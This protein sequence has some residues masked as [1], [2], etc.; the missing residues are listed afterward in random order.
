MQLSRPPCAALRTH[1][2]RIWASDGAGP[3]A[4][5]ARELVVPTGSVHLVF[6]LADA[7]LRVLAD[8]TDTVDERVGCA[9]VGGAR[10]VSYVRDVSLP[11]AS[12]GALL[13]P[14]AASAMLG[15]PAAA[16]SGRHVPLDDL[17]SAAAVTAMRTALAE[18]PSLSARLALFESRLA[19]RLRDSP[20]LDPLVAFAL[21]RLD[22]GSS[23]GDLVLRSGYSH[24]HVTRRFADAVGL[25][26]KTYGRLLRFGRMLDRLAASPD[27]AWSDLA[28]AAGYA[29]QPHLTRE[30][31]EFAGISPGTYRRL[32][33]ANPRHVPL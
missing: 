13:R 20:P 21:D 16:V 5:G 15:V 32:A 2:E 26:P 23:V 6:R 25:T 7:P 22:R 9:L 33:P 31:A 4:R 12:V 19:A 11:V 28:A 14:G 3:P 1:V 18:T 17:W 24:R 29:D 8:L 30:F 27:A 10:A